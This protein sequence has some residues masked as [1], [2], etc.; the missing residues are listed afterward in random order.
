MIRAQHRLKLKA[1]RESWS[2][3]MLMALPRN[4]VKVFAFIILM[5]FVGMIYMV[6]SGKNMSE[7]MKHS[8]QV[9]ENFVE[10][11]LFVLMKTMVDPEEKIA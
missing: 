9:N 7:F 6:Y 10:H 1:K 4:M 5:A 8:L 2:Y 3:K 11:P